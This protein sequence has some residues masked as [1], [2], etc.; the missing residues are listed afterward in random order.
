MDIQ[1]EKESKERPGTIKD[2][3]ESKMVVSTSDRDVIVFCDNFD[4]LD[5]A[6]NRGDEK[7]IPEIELNPKTVNEKNKHGWTP[8]IISSSRQT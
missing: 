3:D 4:Q 6:V 5:H 1:T 2:I 7:L 8:L